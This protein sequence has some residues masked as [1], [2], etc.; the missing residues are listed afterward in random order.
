MSLVSNELLDELSLVADPNVDDLLQDIARTTEDPSPISMMRA[1]MGLLHDPVRAQTALGQ[2]VQAF[3]ETGATVPT[4]ADDQQ[5][6]IAQR[7]FADHALDVTSV[8]FYSAL[9]TCYACGDGAVIVRNT[10]RLVSMTHRR[11][12]ETAQFIFDVLAYGQPLSPGIVEFEPGSRAYHSILGVRLMHASVR[13]FVRTEVPSHRITPVNQQEML[14]T[15]LAFS[16]VTLR[17]LERMGITVSHQEQMAYWHVWSVV[18]AM[19]GIDERLL[20]ID[21]AEANRLTDV[22]ETRLVKAT[23][24]GSELMQALMADMNGTARAV[25]GPLGRLT[26]PVHPALVR[27]LCNE[28][29]RSALQLEPSRFAAMFVF[30]TRPAI[31][32]G[33]ALRKRSAWWRRVANWGAGR[34]LRTYMNADRGAGRPPFDFGLPIRRVDAA[35]SMVKRLSSRRS[36]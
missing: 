30:S 11:T 26:R 36:L 16:T 14:G 21:L 32:F 13:N 1:V 4:W 22:L 23:P 5:I 6:R 12:S 15:I 8:L 25:L 31:R 29:V 34:V 27:H 3:L 2:R 18:G 17:G 10:E 7:F 24:E 33:Q 19:L 9:P 20:T 28:S 35:R